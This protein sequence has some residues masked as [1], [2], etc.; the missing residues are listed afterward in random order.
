MNN[1]NQGLT[2][3]IIC[4]LESS[5]YGEGGSNY[6]SLKKISRADGNIYTYISRQALRYSIINQLID[7][8]DWKKTEVEAK[9]KGNRKVVQFAPNAKIK[10]FAEIDL[11][12]YMKTN[13]DE[14]SS[15][16][17]RSAV[18]RLSNAISMEPYNSNLDF[19]TNSGIAKRKDGLSNSLVQV[20]IH[21][22][23]YT[24]T[25]TIDLN[26]IGID[27]NEKGDEKEIPNTEKA[28]RVKEFLKVLKTLYRDIRGRRENLT[29]IFVIGGVYNIKNPFF[30]NKLHLVENTLKLD[31]NEIKN[32]LE[33]LDDEIE[34]NTIIGYTDSIFKNSKD[35]KDSFK[36]VKTIKEVFDLLYKK[37]DEYY[38]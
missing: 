26:C 29:P 16:M 38:V 23:L 8:Y 33:N 35:I 30:E 37:V 12:G 32:T 24:Y 17:T 18:V 2:L 21:K 1:K 20:E 3:S 28:K 10:D 34:K 11:F 15:T 13:S 25:I 19:L 31:I 7:E 6:S 27:E 9:G 5:N 22:S 4:E 14:D 36:D